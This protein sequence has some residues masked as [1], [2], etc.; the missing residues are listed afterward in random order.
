MGGLP[1]QK[2]TSVSA[3][4]V[5]FESSSSEST[6]LHLT[7]RLCRSLGLVVCVASA[8]GWVE[9]KSSEQTSMS[10]SQWCA[11]RASIFLQQLCIG[12]AKSGLTGGLT[13]E[14]LVL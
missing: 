13:T 1:W 14:Q 2:T 4:L 10:Q 7:R 11:W 3:M 5:H 8:T 12:D 9:A 6:G